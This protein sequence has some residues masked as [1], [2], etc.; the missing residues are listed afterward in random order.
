MKVKLKKSAERAITVRNGPNVYTV[1]PGGET[2]GIPARFGPLFEARGANVTYGDD[3]P[4][5]TPALADVEDEGEG[6]S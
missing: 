4:E 6:S 5:P 3:E 2:E 1:E